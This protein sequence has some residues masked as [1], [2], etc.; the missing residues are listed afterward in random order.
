[1]KNVK[2][3]CQFG[4]VINRV[5]KSPVL[6]IKRVRGFGKGAH[7]SPNFI[8]GVPRGGQRLCADR[9]LDVSNTCI[10]VPL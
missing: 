4:Q 9:R 6:A 3:N 1:M 7:N 5:G 10:Q 2:K 8:L